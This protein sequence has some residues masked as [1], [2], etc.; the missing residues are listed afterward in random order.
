MDIHWNV[1]SIEAATVQDSA[2]DGGG[3]SWGD[4]AGTDLY[5]RSQFIESN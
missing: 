1:C 4:L 2:A 5:Q 3:R